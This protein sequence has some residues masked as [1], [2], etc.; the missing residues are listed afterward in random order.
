MEVKSILKL[1]CVFLDRKDLLA[2]EIFLDV[3][4]PEYVASES[5]EESLKNLL[6]CFNLIVCEVAR[7][8]LPLLHTE[9]IVFQE[10]KFAYSDLQKVI[11]DVFSLTNASGK[12]IRY[13]LFPTF[14]NASV[15]QAEITYSYE[16]QNFE[17]Y[18]E[19][20]SFAGRIPARVLAYGVAMEFC[21]LSSLSTEA[22]IWE[23]RYKT[24]LLAIMRKKSGINLPSRRWI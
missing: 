10:D 12:K 22:L 5:R 13:K 15:N 11:L 16:P 17:F 21:F 3:T 19:I 14:I 8:Y 2:D 18:D 9:K 24:S 1:A 20:T 7:D 6:L 4:P 23:E